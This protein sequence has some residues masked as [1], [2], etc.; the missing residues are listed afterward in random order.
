MPRKLLPPLPIPCLVL[1]VVTA[2]VQAAGPIDV[3][4][5]PVQAGADVTIQY[6]PTG[7]VLDGAAQV[8]LHHGI[9]GWNP[10]AAPD[11]AMTWNAGAGVWEATVA[12]S[13]DATQF[14]MVFQD[15]AG[16]WDNNG[17]A[18]WHLFV[19]GGGAAKW[20]IDGERDADALPV[21]A[22][23]GNTLYAGI[24]GTTLYVAVPRAAGGNDHFVFVAA[25]PGSPHTAPWDKNGTVAHWSAYIGNEVDNGWCG[26]FE[27]AGASEV[28]AGAW[29]EGTLDLAGEFGSVPDD[30]YLAFAAYPTDVATNLQYAEQVPASVN[31][32]GNLDAA[33]YVHVRTADITLG[34]TRLDLDHDCDVDRD[35]YAVFTACLAGPDAPSCTSAD[36]D[37]DGDVDL[38]DFAE[39]QRAVGGDTSAGVVAEDLGANV[40]RFYPADVTLAELPPSMSLAITP[41]VTGP[42]AQPWAVT[43]LFLDSGDR[44][45]AYLDIADNVSL[46]GTGEIAGPLL[47]NGHTSEAWNTDAYGYSSGNPSLYQSHPWV[48]AVRPDGTSFGVLA[49]TTYRCRIDL[50]FDIVFA[51]EGPAFPLYVFTGDSPQAVLERLADFIGRI[52]MPPLWALGYQQCR[53]SYAPESVARN[54]ASEFRN[55]DIPCDVIWFDI[56][57]MDGYRIFTFDP[58]GFPDPAALNNDL[59]AQGFHTVW[60]IDPAPKIESGYFVYDQGCAGDHWVLDGPGGNWY[61]GS[62]W[63]GPTHFPDFTQPQTR[64]WWAGLYADFMAEGVDGVWNDMNEPANFGGPNHSLPVTAWHRGGGDLPAGPHRQYHNVYG[65]LMAESSRAGILAANP[66]KRP[67]VLSRAN[68]IGG[69]RVAAMWTG[70]NVASWEHLGYSTPMVLNLGLSGQPFAGPDLGGFVGDGTPDLFARWMGVGVF[71]PFCRAH[72]DDQG[73]SK[74]PWSFGTSVENASRTAI[75]RRYRL[76]PYLYTLFHEAVETGLP[77]ARPVF[78]AD[79]A[80]PALRSEDVAFLLG[81]DLL[82]VPN[83][84]ENAAA[85]PAPA[86]PGGIWRTLALVGENSAADVNQPDLRLRGG[87]ILPLGPVMEYTN[88]QPLSPLT[89]MISLDASGYAEG[90]LYEDDGDGWDFL[91]GDYRL[92]RYTATRSGNTVTVQ[93]ADVEGTRPTPTRPVTIQV[94]TDSGT[95]TATGADTSAGIVGTVGL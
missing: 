54:I 7:R 36:L 16:T 33:E 18:D 13:A 43:P 70:D 4:P 61:A 48:L 53:F 90:T 56:D 47:R 78:F 72:S 94:V 87:A 10:T 5:Y 28:A 57:Y 11:P 92:A 75:Q 50:T 84:T 21:A 38:G 60:M 40:T 55:R 44:H 81:A 2:A 74:E 22:N 23:N 52:E 69:Q 59:H 41:T 8:Y 51:A 6:D 76:M 29:L 62:V 63:P 85:A 1:C 42:A 12:V 67:F 83:V 46:Y 32:D 19:V 89:L 95:F 39:Y 20:E 58:F 64:A 79:P 45:V 71:M 34:C 14:D 65:M 3:S 15:G 17:G 88:E 37:G 91:A 9:N 86:L 30:L 73:M 66:N 27:T 35:D 80:D 31:N 24:R 25:A 77:V 68:F 93:V 49:D 26:W 82:V